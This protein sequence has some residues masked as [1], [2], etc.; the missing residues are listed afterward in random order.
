VLRI[1]AIA[2]TGVGWI[3]A[4]LCDADVRSGRLRRLLPEWQREAA[5]IYA[6]FPGG[7][8]LAPKVRAFVA[9]LVERLRVRVLDR[10]TALADGLDDL[11][12]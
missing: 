1:A 2:G 10:E 5:E 4:F 3:P 9:F 12:G 6:L 7:R 8:A 11:V